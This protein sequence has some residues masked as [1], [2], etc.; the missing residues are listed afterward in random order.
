MKQHQAIIFGLWVLLLALTGP[1]LAQTPFDEMPAGKYVLDKTHA[2]LTWKVSHM[3]L[4]AYTARF[5]EFDAQLD[6]N[7][8][9]IGKSQVRVTVNPMSIETDYP[10]PEKTDFDKKLST[11]ADWFN[12]KKFPQITFTSKRIKSTGPNT[13]TM[14]GDLTFLGVT[15]AVSLDVTLNGAMAEQ[16]FSK[17]PTLGFSATGGL[18]RS[19]WGMDTYVPNI[20]DEVTLLIEAEFALDK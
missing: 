7:P 1:A 16:P 11:G 15:Q 4:S 19:D 14:Q 6:Y 17:K 20:G 12:A 9:N 8:K 10:N 3:G 18:K 2:S 5:T 13:A